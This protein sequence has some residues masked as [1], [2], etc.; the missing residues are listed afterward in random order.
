MD[1]LTT[2]GIAVGL[3][4]DATAV[5]AAAAACGGKTELRRV[6]RLSF[7]FGLFQALMP[8][9]G[10][11]AGTQ[12]ARWIGAY[13]HWV[14]FSLLEII[15]AKM[16]VEVFRKKEEEASMKDLS[17]GLSLVFLSIATSIDALAVG[18]GFALL[19][20][21]IIVPCL[22]IGGVTMAMSAAAALFGCYLGTRFRR[23]AAFAGGVTLMGIG[24]KI[25]LVG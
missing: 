16:L 14:A 20:T 15:G 8:A 21:S 24:L 22:I 1:L 4:M 11:L 2:F 12:F 3:A 17:R 23:I 13:D 9:L 10:W 7:H 6:F 5:S 19:K 18:I 25:L